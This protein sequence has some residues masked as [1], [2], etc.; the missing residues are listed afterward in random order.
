MISYFN[1]KH[2]SMLDNH[3]L[4]VTFCAGAMVSGIKVSVA[5]GQ[6]SQRKTDDTKPPVTL[7]M[8]HMFKASCKE[9][10]CL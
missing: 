9:C 10:F 5:L 1:I 2:F 4:Q 3:P 7:M 8:K 6:T